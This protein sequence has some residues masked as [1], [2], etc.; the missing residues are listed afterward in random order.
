MQ[1]AAGPLGLSFGACSTGCGS[2]GSSGL[3][4]GASGDQALFLEAQSN[5][6]VWSL[7]AMAA[8]WALSVVAS[9]LPQRRNFYSVIV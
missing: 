4:D 7:E 6:D 9:A 1:E 8:P 5:W 2:S 3:E